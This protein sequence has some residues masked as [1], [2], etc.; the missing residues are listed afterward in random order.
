MEIELY[1]KKVYAVAFRLTGNENIASD[2]ATIAITNIN[3]YIKL[4]NQVTLNLFQLT[5]IELVKIFLKKP[6]ACCNNI[7]N[8]IDIQIAL[9]KIKPM[10]RVTVIWKDVLGFKISDNVPIENFTKQELLKELACG[11]KE[12][13]ELLKS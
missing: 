13:I 10:S 11:R 12:M 3:K 4:E 2:M 5:I 8:S 6:K 7:N 1:F 9:L